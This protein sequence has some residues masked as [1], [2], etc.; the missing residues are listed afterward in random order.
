MPVKF[1]K[2]KL[3]DDA[4]ESAA[5]LDVNNNGILDIVCGAYW[6]EGPDFKKRHKIYE[7]EMIDE[8]YDDFSNIAMD[9]N[10]NGLT[11][12]L[13]GAVWG[14][15]LRWY[16]NPGDPEK[17]WPVHIVDK[18]GCIER[19]CAWDIDGD[20]RLEI[21]P[22][23]PGDPVQI[24]KLKTDKDGKGTGEFEKT[25]VWDKPQGH[26]IGAGDITGNGRCDIILNGGWL[27]APED[28]YKEDWGWHPEFQTFWSASTPML[29]VDVTGNGIGDV[30]VGGGHNY[31]LE[32]YEQQRFANG[33]RRWIPHSIDP[34]N[35]QYHDLQWADIDGDGACELITGKRYR[36][37]NGN[38]PGG[39]DD[40]GLYY[41]KWNGTSFVKQ[42]IDYGSPDVAS[43]T[44]IYFAIADLN[45]NGRL[46]IVAP[47]KE[48]LH[49]FEN[50]GS[51]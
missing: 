42:V 31:G 37:H 39:N 21:V 19:A 23:T 3:S 44:G 1:K 16:E 12:Y 40:I 46:D 32:W 8:Y 45:G 11:D 36:A 50:L 13:T 26:G 41:F 43:G 27:E 10:G 38:D 18:C 48:G 9:I 34:Y 17:Q 7:P 33:E 14:A 28:P 30:I 47:G 4:F 20:G 49:L 24:F 22:N 29:V 25:V 15:A 2:T 6:Y 51:E 35:S 5:A